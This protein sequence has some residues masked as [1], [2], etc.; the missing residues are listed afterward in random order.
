M[1]INNEIQKINKKR[2]KKRNEMPIEDYAKKNNIDINITLKYEDDIEDNKNKFQ[3]S[4]YLIYQSNI[5]QKNKNN[6]INKNNSYRKDSEIEDILQNPNVELHKQASAS[7]NN[8]SF[9]DDNKN[10]NKE[11]N[12]IKK[13]QLIKIKIIKYQVLLIMQKFYPNIKQM[14]LI[15]LIIIILIL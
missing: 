13:M 12:I 1:S 10:K 7:T 8:S 9:D 14:Y 15:F 11:N 5:I 3:K 6:S 2:K 4:N